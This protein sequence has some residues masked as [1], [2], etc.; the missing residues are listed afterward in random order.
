MNKIKKGFSEFKSVFVTEDLL[1]EN[2]EH[3]NIVTATTMLNLFLVI[4]I[5]WWLTKLNNPNSENINMT[6]T[7]INCFIGLFIPAMICFSLKGKKKW[8]KYMLLNMFI[9]ILVTIDNRMSYT[10]AFLM[11]IPVILSARYYKKNFT[12]LTFR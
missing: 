2:E 8:I 5:G 9:L 3:A 10:T 11:V 1:K 4:L 7:L 12:I 6:Y